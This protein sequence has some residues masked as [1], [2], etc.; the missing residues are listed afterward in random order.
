MRP[1]HF[2]ELRKMNGEIDDKIDRFHKDLISRFTKKA[3]IAVAIFIILFA[4]WYVSATYEEYDRWKHE[5]TWAIVRRVIIINGQLRE[6][7]VSFGQFGFPLSYGVN[8]TTMTYCGNSTRNGHSV[9]WEHACLADAQFQALY[10]V[11]EFLGH[12]EYGRPIDYKMTMHYY[13]TLLCQVMPNG[14]NIAIR[15]GYMDGHALPAGAIMEPEEL[16]AYEEF[17]IDSLEILQEVALNRLAEVY[18]ALMSQEVIFV[19]GKGYPANFYG[20]GYLYESEIQRYL[21]LLPTALTVSASPSECSMDVL[22]RAAP[23]ITIKGRIDPGISTTIQLRFGRR[24][25]YGT[26]VFDSG[27]VS[28]SNAGV[29]STSFVPPSPGDYAIEASFPGDDRYGASSAET[30]VAV[31]GNYITL[32]ALMIALAIIGTIVVLALRPSKKRT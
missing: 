7:N 10:H 22:T 4:S 9:Y 19:Q 8:M 15:F 18:R 1:L 20:D 23:T 30:I 27:T 26:V 11:K 31:K 13:Y 28:T 2:Y 12:V 6:L 25:S 24:D 32:I 3:L 16:R 14:S 17:H 5:D 29:F 21:G